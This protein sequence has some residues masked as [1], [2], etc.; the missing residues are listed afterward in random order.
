MNR[1][2]PLTNHSHHYEMLRDILLLIN[3]HDLAAHLSTRSE[4][5]AVVRSGQKWLVSGVQPS[6]S[7]TCSAHVA[8]LCTNR[9]LG[10]P[11]NLSY[12]GEEKFRGEVGRGL[13]YEADKLSPA[14]QHAL[15]TGMGAFAIECMRTALERGARGVTILARRRGGCSPHLLDWIRFIRPLDPTTFRTDSTGDAI[16]FSKWTSLYQDSHAT[17]PECWAEGKLKPDGHTL[18]VSDIF[19]VA[20]ALGLFTTYVGEVE[21]CT[22]E[23]VIATLCDGNDSLVDGAQL[24]CSMLIKCVG[25]NINEG[26][27]RLLGHSHS[28]LEQSLWLVYEPHLDSEFFKNLFITSGHMNTSALFGKMML[29]YFKQPITLPEAQRFRVNHII[30]S[31]MCEKILN[32]LAREDPDGHP[33]MRD[34]LFAL[35]RDF[36]ATM[37]PTAYLVHNGTL[38]EELHSMLLPLCAPATPSRIPYPFADILSQLP[39]TKAWGQPNSAST[40]QTVALLENEISVL[41]LLNPSIDT[42]TFFEGKPPIDVLRERVGQLVASNLWVAGR[43]VS[44][45]GGSVELWVPEASDAELAFSHGEAL[46]LSASSPPEEMIERTSHLAVKLGLEC[47]DVEE[48]LF[49]VSLLTTGE[50]SFALH[51]SLS[52]TIGDAATYYALYAMLDPGSPSPPT[53]L[54]ATRIPS[55]NLASAAP[56]FSRAWSESHAPLHSSKQEGAGGVAETL[57]MFRA[58][59]RSAARQKSVSVHSIDESWV[60]EAKLTHAAAAQAAG[61]GFL[62]TNDILASWFFA[63]SGATIGTLACDCRGRVGGVPGPSELRPGNYLAP[64]YLNQ[65]ELSTPVGVRS[66]VEATIERARRVEAGDDVPVEMGVRVGPASMV[67][68]VTN[69]SSAYRQINFEGCNNVAHLPVLD[70]LTDATQGNLYIFRPRPGELAALNFHQETKMEQQPSPLMTWRPH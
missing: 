64:I 12:K 26:N 15:I 31:E 41:G 32:F 54:D 36:N 42:L 53:R 38:W 22:E 11:R 4:V 60:A 59:S 3:Q 18:S 51:V 14:G 16:I 58:S 2:S 69:W 37:A 33:E 21:R 8:A 68:N 66:K 57:A 5:R 35:A 13:A 44:R 29:K 65:Q 40:G 45:E 46:G 28:K 39:D 55:F 27:E 23:G 7:F 48:P 62:S 49:R 10:T 1:P 47:I 25:F 6:A 56:I 70:S 30:A 52:H 17:R 67:C 19:F 63:S 20:H 24:P 9:R 34:S 43:L 50:N 61:F